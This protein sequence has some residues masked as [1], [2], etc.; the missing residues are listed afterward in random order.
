MGNPFVSILSL[1]LHALHQYL[2]LV[3]SLMA[4][5]VPEPVRVRTSTAMV[6]VPVQRPADPWR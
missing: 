5:W 1:Q 3:R 6:P 2:E 4:P